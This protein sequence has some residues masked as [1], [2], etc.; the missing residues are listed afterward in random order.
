MIPKNMKNRFPICTVTELDTSQ[1]V[2][3]AIPD[4]HGNREG[5]AFRLQGR[6]LAY[7]NECAHVGLP[8][9]WDDADFFSA[10]HS[11]LICKNHGAAF[12]PA[13]GHCTAGPCVGAG[14]KPIH[15]SEEAGV[16][17]AAID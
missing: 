4:A 9:D 12:A 15:V 5:F 1:A 11:L 10:D 8:L 7:Y 6:I 17:Y 3:F 13:D 16:L 2:K 14:L